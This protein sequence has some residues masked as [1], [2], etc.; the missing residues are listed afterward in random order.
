MMR[1]ARRVTTRLAG[2]TVAAPVAV[3][4]DW[5]G[6]ATA[7]ERVGAATGAGDFALAVGAVSFGVPILG[8]L[9]FGVLTFGVPTFGV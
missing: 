8:V 2:A 7:G 9:T 1:A 3:T 4:T 5:D 6:L